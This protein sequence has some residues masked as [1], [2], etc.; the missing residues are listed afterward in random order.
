MSDILIVLMIG[1]LFLLD[2][3]RIQRLENRIRR[4]ETKTNLLDII[5][6]KK[7]DL[8]N[9]LEYIEAIKKFNDIT[10]NFRDRMED[11]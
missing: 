4:L 3:F 7:E 8:I 2:D 9:E 10:K 5:Y 1:G 11:K 6:L